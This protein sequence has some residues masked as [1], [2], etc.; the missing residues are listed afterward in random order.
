[1]QLRDRKQAGIL[2]AKRLS[3]YAFAKDVIVLALPRGGVPVGFE[4]AKKLHLPMD[5]FLVRKLGL[6][7]EEELAV[8]AI[9]S[10]NVRVLN[11]EILS[12]CLVNKATIDLITAKEKKEMER[13]SRIYRDDKPFPI[14]KGKKIILVDD[15]IATGSTI[16]AAIIALRKLKP[17][18][19]IVAAPVAPASVDSDLPEADDIVC[20]LMPEPFY[21]VGSWYENFNQTSD[22]EVQHLLHEAERLM[23]LKAA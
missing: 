1:M 7:G 10:G 18:R 23:Y 4:I 12:S 22:H 19:I 16:R 8:G 17:K 2:L 11:K 3:D 5:V 15:G 20:L 6:P 9:A 13:R 14:I 21:N